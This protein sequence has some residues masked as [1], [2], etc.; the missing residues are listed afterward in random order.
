M[1]HATSSL[2]SLQTESLFSNTRCA[3]QRL[4][5]APRASGLR[6]S[7]T[8]KTARGAQRS[9]VGRK[10][11]VSCSGRIR[12]LSAPKPTPPF[13]ARPPS[14]VLSSQELL[15]RQLHYSST[16]ERRC[17]CA[18]FPVRD[19][20]LFPSVPRGDS[21]TSSWFFLSRC[22]PPWLRRLERAQKPMKTGVER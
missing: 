8:D 17:S 3:V 12:S 1:V 22:P 19:R 7:W 10:R 20:C 9:G 16:L 4:S 11:Q 6:S 21:L 14:S 2:Q 5:R 18:S 15:R 13:P